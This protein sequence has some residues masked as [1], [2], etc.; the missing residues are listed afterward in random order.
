MW[1]NS[2]D[3]PKR[4]TKSL[5]TALF[6][7]VCMFFVCAFLLAYCVTSW[8]A[9]QFH[10]YRQVSLRGEWI[11]PP[12][13]TSSSGYFRKRFDINSSVRHAWISVAAKEGFEVSVN[14]NPVGRTYLWRPTRPFQ[15]GTS[16]SGQEISHDKPAMSLNFPR[17]Y[18]WDGHHNW[19]LPTYIELTNN[20]QIGKNVVCVEVESRSVQAA[21]SFYGEIILWNGEVI[22][23]TSDDTW[24]AE[25]VPLGPQLLDWTEVAYWDKDWRKACLTQ[26]PAQ[27]VWRNLPEE[28]YATV[29][30][31]KWMRSSQVKDEACGTFETNWQINDSID[32]AWFR[33]IA[34]RRYEVYVN[35]K[36]VE[37]GHNRPSDLDNGSW[38]V[39]RDTALDPIAAP[40]LFDPDEVSQFF[41]GEKFENPRDAQ[42]NLEEFKN[43][44]PKTH[45]PYRNYKT[46]NRA[47]DGGEFDPIRTLAES[48][49]TPEKPDL[50]AE[51]PIPSSLK[52]DLGIGGY[53]GYSIAGLLRTGKNKIEIRSIGKPSSNWRG[54]FAV[55][56]M[57]RL[58]SGEIQFLPEADSWV[59]GGEHSEFMSPVEIGAPVS[60][61]NQSLP[62]FR[63][64]GIAKSPFLFGNQLT[65]LTLW[66]VAW[67]FAI[68]LL[69]ISIF[70]IE[71]LIFGTCSFKKFCTLFFDPSIAVLL[72]GSIVLLCG[73][74]LEAS[75]LER[76]ESLWFE[77]GF[78]WNC[79]LALSVCVASLVALSE[80]IG[81]FELKDVRA[82]GRRLLVKIVHLPETRVWPYIIVWMLL[83]CALTRG[84][85]LDL[86]PLDDDEYASTQAITAI[87]KTGTPKFEAE[88]VYYTR[89]PLFHYLTAAIAYPF[90]GN[91]W[92]LRLQ[93][94]FWSMATVLLTYFCGSR[95]LHS[96]WLGLAAMLL[97]TI[98]P[99]EIFTGHVIRFYQMQQFFALLTVFCF[100][101]G[102]V[103][104][105]NQNYRIASILVFLC[106]ILSQEISVVIG[107]SLVLGY[108]LF[109]KDLGWK[110]NFTLIIVTAA[111]LL[112]VAIDFLAFKTLCLTRTEGVSPNVEAAV[113]PHFWY[114][115]N[116][117]AI[118]VGYS[119]LHV[120]P[121]FFLFLGLPLFWRENNRNAF[122][123]TMFLFSGVLMTNLLV[124]HVSLR[125]QYWLFPL[126]ILVSLVS[127][128]LV[129]SYAVG[130]IYRRSAISNRHLVLL[131]TTTTIIL[132]AI[133]LS[134]SPW[135][136]PGTYEM[137]VLGD[138]TGCVRWVQSQMRMGDKLAITEPHTH[139]GFLEAG[140][141]DY[142]IAIPLLYD[143]AVFQDG[144]LVD[145]NGGAE[146]VS[147]VDDL[148]S[149]IEKQERVWILLNREKFRTR[150]KNLRWEY[151]GARFEVFLRKNCELKHR[152]YLWHAYLW[153]S[154]RG[155]YVNFNKQQ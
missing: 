57:A 124:S 104:G 59:S 33:I 120:I 22:A 37:V 41:V 32:E 133:V 131:G 66:F 24:H 25:P 47:E 110:H 89:S 140:K 132:A 52:R 90:G 144:R 134:W 155:H 88:H 48:R 129:L 74:L 17:E 40:E 23:I 135:R 148:I 6:R 44:K 67:G 21:V 111:V 138:S 7:L 100:C 31:G 145:R 49:R 142:D 112:I 28:L 78:G 136:I 1:P 50:P 151:P 13:E 139:A 68:F 118:F 30:D 39:G 53:Y 99:F 55:D 122:A 43:L 128:R 121:S 58:K 105:Q 19:L 46:T 45:L 64:R 115:L 125:Y 72:S 20:F 29:F 27:T 76:H 147:S 62:S 153:D 102:F 149:V 101:K 9:S 65:Q 4:S 116:L 95:L 54:M 127:I 114:P 103:T 75:F 117:F 146:I 96:R 77:T 42:A 92:S 82:F 97:L 154:A 85:K 108:I 152:T 26:G 12:G 143:F 137:R 123:I 15:N 5:L 83:I 34:N 94:V 126:W 8:R 109:A 119:R 113:K 14:R 91:L 150:G 35:E 73:I 38:V 56:G 63:Y 80:F 93:S 141:V 60:H 36:R 10:P 69:A 3:N 79:T 86:Q 87:L 84:Y 18:Q 70:Q 98:H 51:N 106:A 61:Q 2:I 16:E 11:K 81:K 71:T 130:W 107:P